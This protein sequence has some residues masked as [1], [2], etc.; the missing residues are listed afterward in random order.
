MASVM[1]ALNA[2][3]T[4]LPSTIYANI[5]AASHGLLNKVFDSAT[6]VNLFGAFL[7]L[8]L[9]AVVYDQRE[10]K[11]RK[12]SPLTFTILTDSC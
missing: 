8:F 3:S 5:P 10:C 4:E 12:S 11:S 1:Q 7:A 6:P 2:S 9:A